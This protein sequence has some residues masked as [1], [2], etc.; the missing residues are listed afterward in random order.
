MGSDVRLAQLGREMVSGASCTAGLAPRLCLLA[1]FIAQPSKREG[2]GSKNSSA[3]CRNSSTCFYNNFYFLTDRLLPLGKTESYSL[4]FWVTSLLL[5]C[6]FCVG[7]EAPWSRELA[8]FIFFPPFCKFAALLIS[9]NNS[10]CAQWFPINAFPTRCQ[11]GCHSLSHPGLTLCQKERARS[12]LLE[13]TRGKKRWLKRKRKFG[14]LNWLIA[15]KR[16]F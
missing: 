7:L 3:N 5:F 10:E 8:A 2:K 1:A 9:N 12:C 15:S 13:Q 4:C 16:S 6:L 14:N 11:L